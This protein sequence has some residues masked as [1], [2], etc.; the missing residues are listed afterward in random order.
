MPKKHRTIDMEPGESITIESTRKKDALVKQFS[1]MGRLNTLNTHILPFHEENIDVFDLMTFLS[2]KSRRIM[3]EIK[4]NM[5]YKNN[6]ATLDKPISK[7][8]SKRRSEALRELK[9]KNVIRKIGQ[10]SFIVN[11][12]LIVPPRENQESVINKWNSKKP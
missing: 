5:N 10:R 2:P 12:Y 4:S 9:Q 6:E 8:H 7:K 3:Y 1:I 11:P